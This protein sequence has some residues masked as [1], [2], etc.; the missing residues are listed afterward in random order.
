[1]SSN[2]EI[3][4][5]RKIGAH[6]TP[7]NLTTLIEWLWT[8]IY[9]IECLE[10]SIIHSRNTLRYNTILGLLL[11]TL[12]GT[13]NITQFNLIDNYYANLVIKIMLT[14]MAFTITINT[15]RIKIYQYQES[16]ED[17]I[18]IKQEWIQF[19]VNIAAELQLPI[20]LRQ[21][22]LYIIENYKGK[23][24]DLLKAE[25]EIGEKVKGKIK[26]MMENDDVKF[27]NLIQKYN[28]I[29]D[30]KD[31]SDFDLNTIIEEYDKVHITP[32]IMKGKRVMN[33][34]DM[35]NRMVKN[36]LNGNQ[37]S[38]YG[39]KIS[40]LILNLV[41]KEKFDLNILQRHEFYD[42]DKNLTDLY[43]LLSFA[44]SNRKNFDN[45]E[46]QTVQKLE[47]P[48]Q[49]VSSSSNNL[50]YIPSNSLQ[51]TAY[52]TSHNNNFKNIE[53]KTHIPRQ[54]IKS[55]TR[56]NQKIIQQPTPQYPPPPILTQ[57]VILPPRSITP[58]RI[59]SIQ[60]PKNRPPSPI[61][62]KYNIN[63]NDEIEIDID[64]EK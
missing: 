37:V 8:S 51:N 30:M 53:K 38:I 54:T 27:N 12:T 14:L 24:L 17:Y 2:N 5:N 25:S 34:K 13:L 39:V 6:W 20:D 64:K 43:D 9:I 26:I 33:D 19:A 46:I 22:A 4:I 21:D 31:N 3:L 61:L 52:T 57:T 23:Y 32:I 45:I 55:P 50:Q 60:I 29:M 18:R 1:M 42:S 62:Q 49:Y 36:F 47:S 10:I 16:L 48:K 11:S 35:V 15:G 7:S 41:F 56:Q 28:Y 58:T 40:N 63:Q 59:P 44:D